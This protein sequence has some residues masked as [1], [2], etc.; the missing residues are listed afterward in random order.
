MHKGLAKRNVFVS[1]LFDVVV[2]PAMAFMIR[3]ITVPSTANVQSTIRADV[4][5]SG[6]FLFD[7]PIHFHYFKRNDG[8]KS[9]DVRRV[10]FLFKLAY[11]VDEINL[12]N[13]KGHKYKQYQVKNK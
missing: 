3:I 8:V 6:V 4:G 1:H 7:T 9:V 12:D 2:V 5:P 13:E 11:V 10:V